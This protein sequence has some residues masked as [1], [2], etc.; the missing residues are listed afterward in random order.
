MLRK[1]RSR[2]RCPQL[3]AVTLTHTHTSIH[4]HRDTDTHTQK[5]LRNTHENAKTSK[6]PLS[7]KYLVN[8]RTIYI[9]IQVHTLNIYIHNI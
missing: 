4:T 6:L 8:E 5:H 1:L 9:Y 2:R 7:L 3:F